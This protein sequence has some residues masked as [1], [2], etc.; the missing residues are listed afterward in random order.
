MDDS[1]QGSEPHRI[2]I[3]IK[4]QHIERCINRSH[5]FNP[6]RPDYGMRNTKIMS[7]GFKPRALWTITCNQETSIRIRLDNLSRNMQKD[8]KSFA[9]DEPA[10]IAED[11]GMGRQ[12]QQS[13]SRVALRTG[14]DWRSLHRVSDGIGFSRESW[15]NVYSFFPN[16]VR[17]KSDSVHHRAS[18]SIIEAPEE[19]GLHTAVMKVDRKD[20]PSTTNARDTKEN[21]KTMACQQQ[22]IRLLQLK[23]ATEPSHPTPGRNLTIVQAK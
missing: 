9:L 8:V 6:A 22:G 20:T 21:R 3:G 5:I 17:R 15:Q 12:A 16:K 23:L 7:Q 1:L 10:S 13:P 18:N 14:D 2:P 11:R 19:P 4:D